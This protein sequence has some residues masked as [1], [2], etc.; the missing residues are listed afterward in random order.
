MAR[1]V[2]THNKTA[3]VRSYDGT[4]KR[5][6]WAGDTI[7][8]SKRGGAG[9]IVLGAVPFQEHEHHVKTDRFHARLTTRSAKATLTGDGAGVIT[10]GKTSIVAEK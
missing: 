8:K 5:T 2:Y 9:T 3:D 10:R 4:P 7:A 1:F 6:N